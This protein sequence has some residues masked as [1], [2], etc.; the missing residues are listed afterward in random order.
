[1]NIPVDIL[2]LLDAKDALLLHMNFAAEANVKGHKWFQTVVTLYNYQE[3]FRAKGIGVFFCSS[4]PSSSTCKPHRWLEYVDL[5]VAPS[6][7]P[8]HS[9][10]TDDVPAYEACMK[11]NASAW[12]AVKAKKAMTKIA[13]AAQSQTRFKCADFVDGSTSR[14]TRDDPNALL[15]CKCP[16]EDEVLFCGTQQ[17]EGRKF[18]VAQIQSRCGMLQ[19]TTSFNLPGYDREGHSCKQYKSRKGMCGLL[20]SPTFNANKLCI[21]CGGGIRTQKAAEENV[22]YCARKACLP[23]DA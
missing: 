4:N 18:S 21:D 10:T 3:Q 8:V 22:A 6:Y 16:G 1:M 14:D 7:V 13:K 9:Y 12:Y 19:K 5:N 20:D 2:K 11:G 23:A 17:I 15:Q